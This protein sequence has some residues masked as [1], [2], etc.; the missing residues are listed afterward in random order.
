MLL[1]SQQVFVLFSNGIL[2]K[3]P[4]ISTNRE[5]DIKL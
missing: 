4:S 1:T 5:E 2:K 3:M